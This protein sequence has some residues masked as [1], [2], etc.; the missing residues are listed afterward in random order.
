MRVFKTLHFNKA[1]GTDGMSCFL[2]K[3]FA[4]ELTPAWHSLFQLSLDLHKIP[5]LWKKTV[6][7]P[8]PKNSSP[9]DNNDYRPVAATSKN[10]LGVI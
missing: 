3:T 5:E 6:I 7:I 1:M 10:E 2:L 8:T 4:D 9:Q